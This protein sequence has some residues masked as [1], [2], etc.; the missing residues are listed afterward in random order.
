MIECPKCGKRFPTISVPD[1]FLPAHD[2]TPAGT[3][4]PFQTYARVTGL[5]WPGGRSMAIVALLKIF[6]IAERPG[7]AEANLPLQTE[8][9]K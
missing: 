5:E 4:L 3:E 6:K 8:L 7:S 9:L 2:C 1:D